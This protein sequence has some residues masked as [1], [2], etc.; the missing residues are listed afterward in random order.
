MDVMLQYICKEQ[1]FWP[2]ALPAALA[3]LFC[4]LA[5]CI[6]SIISG[7]CHAVDARG[8]IGQGDDF[9]SADNTR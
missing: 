8:S 4:N 3:I 6:S 5:L 9:V 7:Q 2:A 1:S